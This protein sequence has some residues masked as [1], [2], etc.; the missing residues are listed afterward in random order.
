MT[1]LG[2]RSH[3]KQ[4]YI[5]SLLTPT[6]KIATQPVNYSK[7]ETFSILTEIKLL[8]DFKYWALLDL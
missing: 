3:E 7:H 1:K 5:K 8:Y 6:I 2:H 4:W